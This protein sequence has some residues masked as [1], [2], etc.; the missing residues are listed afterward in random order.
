MGRYCV[1]RCPH[2]HKAKSVLSQVKTTKCSHCAKRF[3]ASKQKTFFST[4]NVEVSS[5]VVGRLNSDYYGKKEFFIEDILEREFDVK[6]GK[7]PSSFDSVHEY[8][9]YRVSSVRGA[10]EKIEIA[11]RLLTEHM[12]IFTADDLCK[13]FEAAGEDTSKIGSYIEKMKIANLIFSRDGV[14]YEY[15]G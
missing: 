6:Q 4:D 12:N 3:D 10:K 11:M 1:F 15:I 2:C 5:E 9:G 14:A 13:T 8:V 7:E